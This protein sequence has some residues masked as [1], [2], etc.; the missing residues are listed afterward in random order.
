MRRRDGAA[1]ICARLAALAAAV[2]FGC[3]SAP[4]ASAIDGGDADGPRWPPGEVDGALARFGAGFLWGSA[5]A[6]HQ[7]EGASGPSDWT[8]WEQIAGHIAGGDLSNEGP[9]HWTQYP[10]DVAAMRA[11]GQN[12]YRFGIEWAK[13]YPT[14]AAFDTDTPDL[15]VVAH[16]HDVLAVTRA[17]GMKPMVTLHHFSLPVYFSDPNDTAAHPGWLDPTLPAAFASFAGRMAAEFGSEVD[18]WLTHN[19]PMGEL[20]LGYVLGLWPP[21]FLNLDPLP[22]MGVGFENMVRAHALG[23][24]EV[25]R[26]DTLDA[27]GD[28]AAALVGFSSAAQRFWPQD[29]ASALDVAS[30]DRYRYIYN[31]AFL[32]AVT[33]GDLDWNLDGDALDASDSAAAPELTGRLDWIGIQY[34]TGRIVRGAE[35]FEPFLGLPASDGLAPYPKTD[36]GWNIY[37]RGLFDV[38]AEVAPYG[39][40]IYVTE[41][42]VADA[43]GGIRPRFVVEHLAALAHALGRGYDVRGY[44]HWST[45]DNFEWQSGFCPRFGLLRVDCADPLRA[46]TVTEGASVY[47][48]IIAAGEVTPAIRAAYPSY[49]GATPCP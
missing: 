17:A 36:S 30:A 39:L 49:A 8:A 42:G 19:E 26:A 4:F 13:I 38:I 41:N 15:A 12:A 20:S 40:P 31:L 28:G 22:A 27:D 16:Y 14:R 18:L 33:L 47:S 29:A 9:D 21:G 5:T 32:N 6:A 1:L 37:P 10:E 2:A 24:D 7:V 3:S 45:I 48:Q 11:L 23:Y 43:A 34:Y 25:H 44:F 35:G 46:R